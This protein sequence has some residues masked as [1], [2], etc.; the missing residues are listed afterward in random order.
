MTLRQRLLATSLAVAVPLAAALFAGAE[1]LRLRDMDASARD[2]LQGR[3]AM[4]D[5]DGCESPGRRPQPPGPGRGAPPPRPAG[6]GEAPPP[7]PSGPGEAPPFETFAY[8]D[9][10]LGRA[11]APP[12]SAGL[13]E[14]LERQDSAVS[15]FDS[16]EG[17]GVE[18]ATWTPWPA[19][20]CA[21]LLVRHAPRRGAVRERTIALGLIVVVVLATSWL[22]AGPV[23]VR[24]R[25][26]SAAVRVSATSRY[27]EAVPVDGRDELAELAAAFNAAGAEIR[28]HMDE[29]ERRSEALRQF[30][31]DTTHDVATPLTVLQGHLAELERRL[32]AATSEGRHA[33]GAVQEAHY[34]SSLIRNLAA[35]TRLDAGASA[36]DQRL[37][38]LGALVE[39]VVARHQPVAR[40]LDVE[41]EHAVPETPFS[42]TS[43]L[44]L[45]EQAVSNLVDNAVRHNRRGG[46][47]AVVLDRVGP[48]HFS[49]RVIDDGPG[50]P[51]AELPLLTE[52]RFRSADART[53]RP[54][55]QGLGLA[56][57]SEALARL[58]FSLQFQRPPDGGLQADIRGRRHRGDVGSLQ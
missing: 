37:V 40:S 35:A 3:L 34:L 22:A 44:T 26:L 53:R 29:I 7:R 42:V 6:P 15:R 24:M 20:R 33:T 17:R 28:E 49:L 43:D 45:L 11:N 1:W 10:F 51:E 58:G 57:A 14:Q 13:R 52:R 41:L 2:Y 46:H 56:I 38:D 48:E 18:I 8:D 31:A 39:R 19:G 36:V 25:R 32:D 30:V 23:I 50:V 12:L 55:G 16:P 54:D 5:P 4:L 47:V 27:R 9:Q 21:I